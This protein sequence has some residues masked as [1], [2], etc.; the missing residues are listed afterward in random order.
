[1]SDVPEGRCMV[2]RAAWE[3]CRACKGQARARKAEATMLANGTSRPKGRKM[4]QTVFGAK[5][6]DSVDR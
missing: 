3:P 2:C 4:E 1:M 6:R 5:E